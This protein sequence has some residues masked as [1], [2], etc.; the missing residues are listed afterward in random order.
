[1]NKLEKYIQEILAREILVDPLGQQQLIDLPRHVREA[2]RLEKTRL[3]DRDLV[4]LTPKDESSFSI[5][6]FV[7]NAALVGKRLDC[8]V[9]LQLIACSA[10]QRR[11]LIEKG[12]NFVVP[13]VQIYLPELL[14]D[15]REVY[16]HPVTAGKRL[17][18]LPSA[19]FLLIF[20]LLRSPWR[21]HL[22][23]YSQKKV[24]L[25]TG[26]TAAAISKAMDNLKNLGL[27]DIIGTKDKSISFLKEKRE[28]WEEVLERNLVRDPVNKRIFVDEIPHGISMFQTNLPALSVY[29]DINPGPRRYFAIDNNDLNTLKGSNALVNPNDQE[30]EI[31]LEIWRYNPRRIWGDLLSMKEAVDPLSLYLS[32]RESKDERIEMALDQVIGEFRW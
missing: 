17:T 11:R 27:I 25:M 7:V 5:A 31:C 16:R 30:G 26:Y 9:L 4:I 3:F 28:L 23:Q 2:F 32:L 13:G 12:I 19:Q 20:H 21:Y 6:R 15:L 14:L 10:L 8:P 18:L 1:M 24:A 29:T 22:A